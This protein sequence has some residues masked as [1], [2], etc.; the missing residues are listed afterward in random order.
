MPRDQYQVIKII[1]AVIPS[2]VLLICEDL[3]INRGTEM[4][5]QVKRTA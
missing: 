1:K 4:I 3:L 2:Q 5:V